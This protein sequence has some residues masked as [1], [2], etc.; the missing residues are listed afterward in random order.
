MKE[1]FAMGLCAAVSLI[2]AGMT[3]EE[4]TLPS[5]NKS[6]QRNDGIVKNVGRQPQTVRFPAKLADG[7]RSIIPVRLP[8]NGEAVIATSRGRERLELKR[9]GEEIQWQHYSVDGSVP[10]RRYLPNDPSPALG[11]YWWENTAYAPNGRYKQDFNV[12]KLLLDWNAYFQS[13]FHVDLATAFFP[14]AVEVENGRIRWYFNDILLQEQ[15]V[16]PDV[17]EANLKI[18][19]TKNVELGRP[20]FQT[21]KPVPA[22]FHLLDLAARFNAEGDAVSRSP[23]RFEQDGSNRTASRSR[24]CP[25]TA[26]A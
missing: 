3:G 14:V 25:P 8:Q 15:P 13:K 11:S 18:T 17:H 22:K 5:G 12:S 23:G 2:P 6:L 26:S 10:N 21:L 19:F 24:S 1:L 16:L 20:V 7:T 4:Y 9:S